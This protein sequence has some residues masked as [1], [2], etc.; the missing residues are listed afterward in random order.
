MNMRK[1]KLVPIVNR[2]EAMIQDETGERQVRRFEVNERER[3]LVTYDNARDMFELEDRTNGQVYEFDDID[4]VAIEI[5][6]LI[7]PTE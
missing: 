5:L 1:S 7:Q 2:L 6:E 4:F 3:C